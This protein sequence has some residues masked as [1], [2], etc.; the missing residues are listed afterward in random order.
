M[1]KRNH[2]SIIV[3]LLL[4]LLSSSS[5]ALSAQNLLQRNYSGLP[6]GAQQTLHSEA[7]RLSDLVNA[8]FRTTGFQVLDVGLYDVSLNMQGEQSFD[9][10]FQTADAEVQG[11]AIPAARQPILRS[12]LNLNAYLL[13]VWQVAADGRSLKLR[14]KLR[15]PDNGT[16]LPTELLELEGILTNMG[17]QVAEQQMAS[18]GLGKW[19]EAAGAGVK[20]IADL[21][22]RKMRGEAVLAG[23]IVLRQIVFKSDFQIREYPPEKWVNS[24]GK[25]LV[26]YPVCYAG[27]KEVQMLPEFSCSQDR[28]KGNIRIKIK[29]NGIETIPFQG[30]F[31]LTANVIRAQDASGIRFFLENKVNHLNPLSIEWF[32]SVEKEIQWEFAGT[33][34][35]EVF[36]ILQPLDKKNSTY[37]KEEYLFYGCTQGKDVNNAI[38]FIDKAWSPFA[39]RALN[40]KLFY[41]K[42]QAIPLTYYRVSE[43][44]C[45]GTILESDS[46][47]GAD[48]KLYLDGECGAFS[49]LWERILRHQGI[50]FNRVEVSSKNDA[51][52][53][54]KH[55]QFIKETKPGDTYPY[56]NAFLPLKGS[57]RSVAGKYAQWDMTKP[58]ALN[59]GKGIPGQNVENPYSDFIAHFI[60]KV[61]EEIFDPSYGVRCKSTKEWAEKSIE[62]FLG[63]FDPVENN[64]TVKIF[65]ARLSSNVFADLNFKE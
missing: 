20:K 53:L 27:G 10:A 30:V 45:T 14:W 4:F 2:H 16:L 55:W 18:L 31:D 25:L 35:H 59:D 64:P 39:G 33:S 22:E 23:E 63:N 3:V 37:L 8:Y 7:S 32:V 38:D 43:P 13:M 47:A 24:P 62:G 29:Y 52:F 21:L 56:Q 12:N 34:S 5:P 51:G 50:V 15:L 46:I 1:P 36:V 65:K 19:A 49:D 60:V 48:K 42:K 54:V 41:P 58:I 44:G 61:G 17:S 26:S 57:P 28:I 9:A 40:R 11:H 6:D